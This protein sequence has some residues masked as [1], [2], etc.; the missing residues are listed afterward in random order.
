MVVEILAKARESVEQTAG[1]G[2]EAG[3]AA[4]DHPGRGHWTIDLTTHPRWP[5]VFPQK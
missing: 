2:V 3:G 1:G 4:Q 5:L